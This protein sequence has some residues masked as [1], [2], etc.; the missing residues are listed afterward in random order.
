MRGV[1]TGEG[2]RRVCCVCVG[3][4]ARCWL[5]TGV[6][7]RGSPITR[8]HANAVACRR[9]LLP[10]AVA[11]LQLLPALCCLRRS[12]LLQ[13]ADCRVGPVCCRGDAAAT[14]TAVTGTTAVP[15]LLYTAPAPASLRVAAT[16]PYAHT[17]SRCNSDA[18]RVYALRLTMA[19]LTLC[20]RHRLRCNGIA[21]LGVH[22]VHVPMGARTELAL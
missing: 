7:A 1:T 18:E 21:K 17:L 19:P 6:R 4:G 5:V 14:T 10:L 9:S 22:V 2:A 3:G 11:R 12:V 8:V 16:T 20:R 13:A 15:G